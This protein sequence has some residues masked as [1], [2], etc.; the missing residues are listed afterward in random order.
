MIHLLYDSDSELN[1]T[2]AQEY[3]IAGDEHHI[4]MPF[5]ILNKTYS[6]ELITEESS[7]AFF[8]LVKD[9]NM[10]S[11]AAL[12]P[13]EYISI[14]EPIFAKGDEIYTLLSAQT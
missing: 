2:I 8:D 12:N 4:K 10:P 13:M 1:L 7:N 6:C 11:T 5:I 9:G 14:L 3:G